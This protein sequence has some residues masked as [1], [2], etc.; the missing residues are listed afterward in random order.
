MIR[1]LL[2]P[3]ND[4]K[5]AAGVRAPGFVEPLLVHGKRSILDEIGKKRCACVIVLE[6]HRLKKHGAYVFLVVIHNLV[7]VKDLHRRSQGEL[8]DRLNNKVVRDLFAKR[9]FPLL[10]VAGLAKAA[11]RAC[12][13]T[14]ART[15]RIRHEL[16]HRGHTDREFI[17]VKV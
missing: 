2:D 5:P 11:T 15:E 17:G 1:N 3:L 10:R 14:T 4:K 16:G 9:F 13:A 6:Q 12:F 8:I 7:R